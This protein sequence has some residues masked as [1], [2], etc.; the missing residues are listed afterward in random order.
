MTKEEQNKEILEQIKKLSDKVQE[1]TE[2]DDLEQSFEMPEEKKKSQMLDIDPEIVDSFGDPV[3]LM[4]KSRLRDYSESFRIALTFAK[5]EYHNMVGNR[6]GK[7]SKLIPV[8]NDDGKENK[9]DM[10][11]FSGNDIKIVEIEGK[12]GVVRQYYKVRLLIY[13]ILIKKMLLSRIPIGGQARYEDIQH[14][15]A[16]RLGENWI[17]DNAPLNPMKPIN[18]APGKKTT[19]ENVGKISFE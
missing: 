14:V 15:G 16:G 12:D 19:M 17:K 5:R 7:H 11:W 18:Y 9:I 4:T 6:F 1:I 3:E 2:G 8:F 13:D 10:V